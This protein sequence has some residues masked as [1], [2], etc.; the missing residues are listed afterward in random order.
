M[1]MERDY[2]IE[3]NEDT[4]EEVQNEENSKKLS[5]YLRIIIFQGVICIIV[6]I[7]CLVIK[8]F[9]GAF[10]NEVK[11]W[12][13]KNFS[14]DTSTSLVLEDEE[15][16]GGQGGPIIENSNILQ[17]FSSPISGVLTSSYGYRSDPFTG[18]PAIHN[19]VDIAAKSGTPIKAAL[20]GV[21]EQAELSNGDYGN[22]IVVDHGGFKTLYAHCERLSVS[23]G[24]KVKSGDAIAT[25][26]ST[27]RSTGPHL[28]FEIQIGEAH[29]DPTPFI[30]I[31]NK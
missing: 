17:G 23:E 24:E 3:E 9:F 29:I 12:Y 4:K 2:F 22:F 21:V 31:E 8:T 20:S 1:K 30:N 14:K 25:V 13:D 26:G 18:E 16:K 27:G 28:H 19:G 15:N 6:I 10:F 11:T 5:P 7:F